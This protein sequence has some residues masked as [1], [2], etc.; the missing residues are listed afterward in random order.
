MGIDVLDLTTSVR[1][2]IPS[3]PDS[4]LRGFSDGFACK[5]MT[6]TLL[7]PRCLCACTLTA[8]NVKSNKSHNTVLS[9]ILAG[10]Y[11]LFVPYFNGIFSGK[12]ARIN[13]LEMDNVQEVD[14]MVD[15]DVPDTLRGTQYS[16][17]VGDTQILFI[18]T[19]VF[20]LSY[21][22]TFTC[23]VSRW[24][25]KQLAGHSGQHWRRAQ[26]TAVSHHCQ[27]RAEGLVC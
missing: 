4:D 3:F 20:T 27:C 25:R 7:Q 5:Y 2:Q 21:I 10:V 11:G 17:E 18:D 14:L 15:R 16:H 13:I 8:S 12:V 26:T 24:I 23:R 9:I 19:H 1:A 22:H 6:T